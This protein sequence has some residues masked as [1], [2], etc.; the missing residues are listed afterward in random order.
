LADVA[1]IAIEFGAPPEVCEAAWLH[2]VL[3]DTDVTFEELRECFCLEVAELVLAVTNKPGKNRSESHALTY[4]ALRAA[5]PTPVLLKLCDRLANAR[6]SAK[7]NPK[8]LRMY[9]DEF[10]NFRKF[11][12]VADEHEELW[13]ELAALL[14]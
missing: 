4:P 14:R 10:R 8:K 2:D 11:L 6:A 1:S 9:K 12:Y 3:E 7:S 13:T 5:G